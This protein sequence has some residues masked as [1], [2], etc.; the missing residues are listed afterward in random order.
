MKQLKY[1]L[2]IIFP[3]L[4]YSCSKEEEKNTTTLK[5]QL[6]GTWVCIEQSQIFGTNTY[7][8][9][10][11]PHS[12]ISTR[13]VIDN[14]Y[15]LGFQESHAQTDV[16]GNTL[17]IINQTINGYKISGTGVLSNGSEIKLSYSTDDGAGVDNVT[18]TLT[19]TN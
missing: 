14:F 2:L 5:D 8:V 10:I 17:T 6:I 11:N 7:S 15:N 16:N 3:I 4:L 18:A 9:D 19:K 1:L 13:V 12:T